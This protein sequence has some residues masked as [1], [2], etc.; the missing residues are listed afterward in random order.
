MWKYFLGRLKVIIFMA[1]WVFKII[2]AQFFFII[3]FEE[4]EVCREYIILL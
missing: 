3:Y 2:I 4:E 1:L